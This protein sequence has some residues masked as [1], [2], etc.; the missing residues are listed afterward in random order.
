MPAPDNGWQ[1]DTPSG[2][3]FR[4]DVLCTRLREIAGG[5]DNVHSV[6]IERHGKLVAELY[7]SGK[8]SPL[9][10]H[11]GLLPVTTAFSKDTLHDARS[12]SKSVV[13]LLVG[14]SIERGKL[15][16]TDRV[17]DYFPELSTYRSNGRERI[18]VRDLLTMSSGLEWN[19]MGRGMLTSSETRLIWQSDPVDYYF[20]RPPI[21]LP[22]QHFNYAGGATAALASLLE[23]VNGK[24]FSQIVKDDLFEPLEITDWEWVVNWRGVPMAYAG[25]RIKPR[26]MLKLGRLMQNGG[27]WNSRQIVPARWIGDTMRPHLPTSIHFMS[28]KDGAV[29]YGYQWWNGSVDWHGRILQWSA[30]I[31]NGGQRIFVVPELDVTIVITAGDYGSADI[32]MVVGQIIAGL[33]DTIAPEGS[34]ETLI[35]SPATGSSGAQELIQ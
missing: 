32:Q 16:L 19:E 12:I 5:K 21:T 2:T 20:D 27:R 25:L 35:Y 15:Q 7:R 31:G 28:I 8:D 26:D 1:V 13:G 3:G 29:N 11:S 4:Q 23:K 9:S 17:L 6:L 22:G 18:E 34:K 30:A 10:V 24:P 14:I 33:L